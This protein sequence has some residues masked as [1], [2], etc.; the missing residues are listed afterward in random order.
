LDVKIGDKKQ[1]KIQAHSRIGMKKMKSDTPLV[2]VKYWLGKKMI[3]INKHCCDHNK[4]CNN[5]LFWKKYPRNNSRS[6]KMET[7]MNYRSS[8]EHI[9]DEVIN[10]R[11][12]YFVMLERED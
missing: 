3:S 5:P 1:K 11:C 12:E 7:V 2:R 4:P 9:Y 6:E 8:L 10:V